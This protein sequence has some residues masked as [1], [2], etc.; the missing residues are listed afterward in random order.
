MGVKDATRTR[1]Q[2]PG[3]ALTLWEPREESR[4]ST[5]SCEGYIPSPGPKVS[6]W[7][8]GC[9][10]ARLPGSQPVLSPLRVFPQSRGSCLLSFHSLFLFILPASCS[11]SPCLRL[12]HL[13][14]FSQHFSAHI[15]RRESP[16]PSLAFHGAAHARSELAGQLP[17][18]ASPGPVSGRGTARA[19]L[20]AETVG[21]AISF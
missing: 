17:S 13:P 5:G 2:E 15:P 21:R 1:E 10:S 3:F 11:Y 9:R 19:A 14:G 7:Q 6:V 12:Q 16:W 20:G 18:G 8:H 4:L